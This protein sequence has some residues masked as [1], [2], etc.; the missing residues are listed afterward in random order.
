MARLAHLVLG[1]A[2]S[3]TVT[4]EQTNYH[5]NA[6]VLSDLITTLMIARADILPP[7]PPNLPR[8]RHCPSAPAIGASRRTRLR[9]T[10][11]GVSRTRVSAGSDLDFRMNMPKSLPDNFRRARKTSGRQRPTDGRNAVTRWTVKCVNAQG[12]ATASG[13]ACGQLRAGLSIHRSDGR[14]CG[15]PRSPIEECRRLRR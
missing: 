10:C 7:I 6:R 4:L 9:A 15:G 3:A 5:L 14:Y 8:T 12:N 2:R 13:D 1:P 11:F